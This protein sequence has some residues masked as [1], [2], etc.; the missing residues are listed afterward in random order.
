MAVTYRYTAQV[1]LVPGPYEI[2]LVDDLMGQ[3]LRP[4]GRSMLTVTR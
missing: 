2:R 3:R 1:P 4:V